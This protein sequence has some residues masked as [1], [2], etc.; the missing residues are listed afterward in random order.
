M[1]Q[2]LF[3]SM[4]TISCI[5]EGNGSVFWYF[6]DELF[7]IGCFYSCAVCRVS[8]S[9]VLDNVPNLTNDRAF[10]ETQHDR[11][12]DKTEYR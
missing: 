2:L 4:F 11:N 10:S 3:Y 5:G 7:V 9:I 1:N 12:T 8:P 6:D